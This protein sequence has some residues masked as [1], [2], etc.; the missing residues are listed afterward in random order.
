MRPTRAIMASESSRGPYTVIIAARPVLC[1]RATGARRKLVC[2]HTPVR[3]LGSASSRITAAMPPT[4]S[5]SGFLKMR[6][7]SESGG[8]KEGAPTGALKSTGG[9]P[10]GWMKPLANRSTGRCNGAGRISPF[11]RPS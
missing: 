3:T 9:R 7:D 1:S 11:M 6:H 2:S 5:A 8:S 4:A 10:G